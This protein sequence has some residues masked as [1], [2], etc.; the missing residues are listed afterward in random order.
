MYLTFLH[1]PLQKGGEILGVKFLNYILNS[2][3][4]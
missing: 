2:T 4:K 1:L 3:K